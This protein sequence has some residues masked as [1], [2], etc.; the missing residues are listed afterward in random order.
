MVEPIVA[1]HTK[2]VRCVNVTMSDGRGGVEGGWV[3]FLFT[4]PH[5]RRHVGVLPVATAITC[6]SKPNLCAVGRMSVL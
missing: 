1:A 3:A 4:F 2:L 5:Q 6:V